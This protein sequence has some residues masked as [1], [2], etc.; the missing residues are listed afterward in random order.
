VVG[1]FGILSGTYGVIVIRPQLSR[2]ATTSKR[3]TSNRSCIS[4]LDWPKCVIV[5]LL[6]IR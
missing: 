2:P 3:Y 1:C 4:V 6:A 5:S